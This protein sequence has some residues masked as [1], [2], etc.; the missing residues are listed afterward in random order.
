MIIRPGFSHAGKVYKLVRA[1]YDLRQASRA[2]YN[3]IDSF[4]QNLGLQR[5][6]EDPNL[7]FSHNNRKH[8]I[9]LLY[10][11][12][13]IITRND[14]KNIQHL[15]HHMMTTFCMT[16]LGN[17][18]YYL[19]VEIQQCPEGTYFHQKGYIEKL[20]DKFGMSGCT[21]ASIRMNPKKKLQKETSFA[22]VDPVLYQSIVGC[23]LH[24]TISRWDIQ[25]AVN[26]I[27]R[28]LTSPQ[29]DH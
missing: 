18:S 19:G 13:I 21:L 28:Y 6:K 22:P 9:I 29:Q 3:R 11:D 15:K 20:L 14:D 1:L 23:L 24:A 8:T 27:S 16:N 26:H 12:D 10:V 4:I 2:W 5:S 25:F 17:V 7:Y